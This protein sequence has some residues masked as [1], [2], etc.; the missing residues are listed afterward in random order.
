MY[1]ATTQYQFLFLPVIIMI[2]RTSS[3]YLA[4]F[5]LYSPSC[6]SLVYHLFIDQM[7]TDHSAPGFLKLIWWW[8][9]YVCVFVCP[10]PRLLITNG[11]I[12]IPYDWFYSC[13]IQGYMA[14]V[15]IIDDGHGL[16]FEAH[17]INRVNFCCISCYF[18]F[19]IPKMN[20]TLMECFSYT[21]GCS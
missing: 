19:N 13:Y 8:H 2:L 7:H 6:C 14:A 12:W 20:V 21:G 16:R 5:F 18:H 10:P 1:L 4:V 3:T 11:M 15:V 17:C 9:L